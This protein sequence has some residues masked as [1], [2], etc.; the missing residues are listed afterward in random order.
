MEI[1]S[2]SVLSLAKNGAGAGE[3]CGV[4]E[5]FCESEFPD[6]PL[7]PGKLCVCEVLWI[8]FLEGRI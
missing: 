6:E 7:I 5:D 3:N 8:F 1:G 2:F 4:F